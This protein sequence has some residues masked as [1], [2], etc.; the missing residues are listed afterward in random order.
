[1]YRVANRPPTASEQRFS[2]PRH[3][4]TNPFSIRW[5]SIFNAELALSVTMTTISTLLS[6]IMLPVNLILYA[7]T[8]YSSD[9]VKNLD[10]T[11]LF[12]SLIV[13]IGGIVSG[14][15]CSATVKSP[16]FN[17][18]MNKVSE[19]PFARLRQ[20][21]LCLVVFKQFSLPS[22]NALI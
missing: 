12:V 14:L 5:C 22:H 7:T 18:L 8:S 13:V 2:R 11:A 6:M 9:V 15:I 3:S 19:R 4:S 16:R 17:L 20:T 21:P 10:W 1:M